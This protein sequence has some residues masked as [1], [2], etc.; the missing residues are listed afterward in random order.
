MS[1]IQSA[2][3]PALFRQIG[4]ALRWLAAVPVI[5]LFSL[6]SR[7][8]DLCVGVEHEFSTITGAIEGAAPGD[9]IHLEPGKIYYE[10]AVIR[11][12]RGEPGKPIVLDGHGAILD[13][14]D[15]LD[16]AKW[17]EVSPGLFAAAELV[18]HLD[19]PKLS[20]WF[21]LWNGVVNRMGRASKG[22][23]E[24]FK[25]PEELMSGEWT[26]VADPE[27]PPPPD[28]RLMV[29]SFYLRLAPGQ[30][31]AETSIR[32]PN[33][34]RSSGVQLSGKNAHLIIRNLTVRHVYND[35]FNIYGHGE[36]VVFENIAAIGC[37]DDGISS[38]EHGQYRVRGFTSIGNS[39]GICD[40][41][42]TIASYE[43][44][45]IADCVSKDINFVHRGR[46]SLQNVL[47]LSSA[48]Q[49]FDIVPGLAEGDLRLVMDNVYIRRLVEPRLGRITLRANV[50]G[51]RCTFENMDLQVSGEAAWNE[52]LLNGRPSEPGA[53]GADFDS[54]KA[55]IPSSYRQP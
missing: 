6:T 29:G 53:R 27:R 15:P 11:D 23:A 41:G 13:G 3:A 4:R 34:S 54:L 18:P 26:F 22:K 48:Q 51:I 43:N 8:G 31:L 44:V 19:E 28:S 30:T 40:T 55:L 7:G 10:S 33:P 42:S 14:T 39:T 35:G 17:R 2:G 46:Y 5:L 21:F 9:T 38:H 47:V 20:R 12:K 52:S 36:E 49:P 37:G 45:F 32:I 25:A 16:P 50:E 24:P 1:F